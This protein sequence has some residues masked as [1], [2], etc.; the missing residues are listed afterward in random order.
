MRRERGI[1]DST[2]PVSGTLTVERLFYFIFYNTMFGGFF[3]DCR[4]FAT[5]IGVIDFGNG[6]IHIN[7]IEER[8]R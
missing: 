4:R 1:V 5:K 8:A 3:E 6:D 7:A 2:M